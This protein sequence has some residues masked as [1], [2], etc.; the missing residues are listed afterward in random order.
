M[1]DIGAFF[2]KQPDNMLGIDIS[3]SGIKLVGLGGTSEKTVLEHCAIEALEA[4]CVV[5][6]MIEKPDEVASALR[7]LVKQAGT[8]TKKVA[9]ALPSSAVITKKLTIPEGLPSREMEDQV[10]IEAKQ[11]IPFP[12]EDVTLDFVEIGP[13]S[14][15]FGKVEVFIAA[16]RRERVDGIK[17]MLETAGLTPVVV[18]V[19]SYALQLALA[20]V[21]D[22][23]AKT[24]PGT[25]S[26]LFKLGASATTMQV[27]RGRDLVYEREQPVGGAQLTQ[28]I[29]SYYGLSLAE[30]EGKKCQGSLAH[31][32]EIRILSPYVDG[33]VQELGRALQFFFNSTQYNK[34]NQVFLA[35]GTAL[36]PGLAVA[37]ASHVQVPCSV[38]NPFEG[39]VL[40]S[41]VKRSR[42]L[43]EAPSYLGACGLALRRFFN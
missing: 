11:Y 8:K 9:L 39:M 20:R 15:A 7:R 16:A 31:D 23:Q 4:G 19:S 30:A 43:Q 5:D 34:V 37:V 6:G 28:K 24:T 10:E 35:G 38:I 36:L 33:M 22:L 3:A 26:V 2:R 13:S 41:S 14:E 12:L 1:I 25:L 42:V 17:D 21:I 40:G 29:A 32:Y 27:L 18:D